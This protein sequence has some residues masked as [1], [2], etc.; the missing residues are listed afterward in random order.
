[1]SFEAL[2]LAATLLRSSRIGM[3]TAGRN[4]AGASEAGYTRQTPVYLE[5][6]AVT[7]L[8][9]A[10]LVEG[11][12]VQVQGIRRLRVD[13]ADQA[14]RLRAL[15]EGE[16]RALDPLL[17]ELEQRLGRADGLHQR[18][19]RL[20][21]SLLG[22][23]MRPDDTALRS[24]TLSQADQLAAE[25]RQASGAVTEIRQEADREL[26]ARVDRASAILSE[27]HDLNRRLVQG[28]SDTMG[29]N[30]LMDQRDRLLDEVSGLMDVRI[31]PQSTGEVFVYQNGLQLLG[32]SGP[33]PLTVDLAGQVLNGTGTA[34]NLQGGALMALQR[35][36][37][38][39]L[40]GYLQEL[41]GLAL[42]LRDRLNEIHR[43]GYGL[44]GVTGR[45]LFAGTA[46]LDLAAAVTDPRH[47]GLSVARLESANP[48]ATGQFASDQPLAGQAGNLTLAPSASGQVLVN[49]VAINW[50]DAQSLDQILD[51]FT[52][53]GVQARW[54]PGSRRVVL[55]RDVRTAGPPDITVAD[56]SGNLTAVLDLAGPSGP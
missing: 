34:L 48:V 47:L 50:T 18:S 33:E 52:A 20:E 25:F 41:D 40:D 54:D 15:E 43:L 21:Q 26:R 32:R 38:A 4:L 23:A 46:A 3:D 49:G 31:V 8:P 45:D 11:L 39:D 9:S 29:A 12:G 27:L 22:L 14:Y 6:H 42:S 10:Q 37:G 55:A 35:L 36:R 5:Q 13:L 30:G 28:A 16:A 24:E 7:P 2:N 17:Q 1:M 56:A 19:V 53:A 51:S 44:D